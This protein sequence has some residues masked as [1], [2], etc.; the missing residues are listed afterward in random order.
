MVAYNGDGTYT[1][2]FTGQIAG[3]AAKGPFTAGIGYLSLGCNHDGA[4]NYFNSDV[5]EVK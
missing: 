3:S 4:Q 2:I 1:A 5:A